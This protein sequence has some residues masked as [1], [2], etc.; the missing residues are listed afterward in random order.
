MK[1]KS[2][3]EALEELVEAG[4]GGESLENILPHK[5]K[6]LEHVLPHNASLELLLIFV[7]IDQLY[8]FCLIEKII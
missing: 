7:T 5:V 3:E 6:S 2:K 4:M 1:G 8:L